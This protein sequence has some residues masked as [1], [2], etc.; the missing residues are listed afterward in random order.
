MEEGTKV[1]VVACTSGHEFDIGEVVTRKVM[2][3]NGEHIGFHSEENGDWYMYPE[4]YE[5]TS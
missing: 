2:W 5:L 4:E 3:E 1:K